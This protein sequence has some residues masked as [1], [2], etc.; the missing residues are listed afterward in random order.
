MGRHVDPRPVGK[1]LIP[2]VRLIDPSTVWE[3]LTPPEDINQPI[4]YQQVFPTQ[5][6]IYTGIDK[7]GVVPSSKFI[8]QQI[9]AEEVLHFKINCVSTSH[10]RAA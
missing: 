2:R 4:A 9:P 5:Y 3:I 1:G 8:M 6:Q 7:G 10:G